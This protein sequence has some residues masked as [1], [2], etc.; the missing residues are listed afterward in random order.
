[1]NKR[2]SELYQAMLFEL[3]RRLEEADRI[4]IRMSELLLDMMSTEIL[5][6]SKRSLSGTSAKRTILGSE[7]VPAE[8]IGNSRPCRIEFDCYENGDIRLWDSRSLELGE[9]KRISGR[10]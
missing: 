4:F 6:D 2:I 7:L 1:M 10:R 3:H 9:K 5:S 8:G